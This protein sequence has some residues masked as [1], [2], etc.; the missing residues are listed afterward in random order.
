M[1]P[2][3]HANPLYRQFLCSSNFIRFGQMYKVML[4]GFSRGI[5]MNPE[6]LYKFYAQNKDGNGTL[7]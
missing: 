6:D 4:Q 7:L 3:K 1:N 2:W 5:D